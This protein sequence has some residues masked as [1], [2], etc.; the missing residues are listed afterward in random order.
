MAKPFVKLKVRIPEYR[1]PRTAWRREIHKVVAE[2]LQ[3]RRIRYTDR[4]RFAIGL[5]LSCGT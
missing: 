5:R 3:Q 2:A 4:D 1:R